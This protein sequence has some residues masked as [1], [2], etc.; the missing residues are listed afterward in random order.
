MSRICKNICENK[1]TCPIAKPY[2]NRCGLSFYQIENNAW[3]RVCDVRLNY[4][5]R[6]CPC[7][8][9]VLR[10]NPAKKRVGISA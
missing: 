2:N 1:E 7:C 3:C 10:R 5:G 8:V 9:T 4:E 6:Y